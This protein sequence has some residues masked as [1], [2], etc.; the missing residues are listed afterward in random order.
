MFPKY[1]ILNSIF[2]SLLISLYEWYRNRLFENPKNLHLFFILL[3][4]CVGKT[5]HLHA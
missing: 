4:F 5:G 1:V 2:F 3:D